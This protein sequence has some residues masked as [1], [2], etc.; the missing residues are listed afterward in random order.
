MAIMTPFYVR[1]CLK[2]VSR[3]ISCIPN[4]P[5]LMGVMTPFEACQRR[6]QDLR[7]AKSCPCHAANLLLGVLTLTLHAEDTGSRLFR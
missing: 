6:E 3:T 5:L 4:E 1:I 7:N 2:G